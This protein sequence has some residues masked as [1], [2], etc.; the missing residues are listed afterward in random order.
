MN[1][2][3][4][5][6]FFNFHYILSFIVKRRTTLTT[7]IFWATPCTWKYFA[8]LAEIKNS[9]RVTPIKVD[10]HLPVLKVHPCNHYEFTTFEIM[11][12]VIVAEL[13]AAKDLTWCS[14]V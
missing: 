5:N 10:R 11:A 1:S 3:R 14:L 8:K 12:E 13:A 6:A 7:K 2:I 4:W 9:V